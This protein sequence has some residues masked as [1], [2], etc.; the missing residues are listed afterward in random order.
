MG[1]VLVAIAFG[2]GY[3]FYPLLHQTPAIVVPSDGSEGAADMGVF[4]QAW[5]LLDANFYGSAPSDESRVHGALRGMVESFDDPYTVYVERQPRELERDRLRGSFG[6][7]GA[8]IEFSETRYLLHPIDGQPAQLAGAQ[9][10]DELRRV[11]AITVTATMSSDEVVSLVRGPIGSTV[12]LGIRRGTGDL[13]KDLAMD[14]VR[15]EI[16]TP[17]IEYRLLKASDNVPG[18]QPGLE[19]IGYL[20]HNI[21]SERSVSEMRAAIEALAGQ[22]ASRFIWDLRGN[23]GGLV[24]AAVATADLWLDS[25]TILVEE[26]ADGSSKLFSATAGGEGVQYPLVV[27]VD[28]GSA[29]ASEIVAGALQDLGRARVVGERTYGKGSVQLIYELADQSSLHVTNAQ[30]FTPNHRPIQGHGL[31]PDV[32]VEAGQDPLPAAIAAVEGESAQR[33][34]ER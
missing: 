33:T 26:H 34:A 13:A 23:P 16:Q 29:S 24:D 5:N 32:A 8:T 15:G 17:S 10:G 27:L 14:V 6:G 19:P 20:R 22:G 21:F 2:A 7:I 18:M 4:W 28:A 11:D 12:N 31:A 25:G 3:G 1:V 9:D 30:W